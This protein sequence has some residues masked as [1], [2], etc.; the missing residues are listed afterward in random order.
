MSE[1]ESVLPDNVGARQLWPTNPESPESEYA[2]RLERRQQLASIRALHQRLWTYVIVAACWDFVASAV[3]FIA[4]DFRSL[5]SAAFGSV[6]VCIQSLRKNAG[7]H[8]RC[9][10]SRVFTNSAW[11][12]YVTSGKDGELGARNS[13]REPS[14]AFDLDLFG[15]GSLFELLCTARTGVGR[16][17]LAKWLLNP[18]RCGEVG[19][20]QAAVAELRDLL[21]LRE[22]WASVEGDALDQA[23]ASVRDWADVSAIVFPLLCAGACDSTANLPNRRV[24]RWRCRRLRP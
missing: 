11:R 7:I 14:Y 2:R 5:D 16:A 9:N 17:M 1:S 21:D 10:G 19:E 12:G 15:K 3:T 4:L 20:R 13:G 22:D 6:P 24:T 23:G 18:A 8:S